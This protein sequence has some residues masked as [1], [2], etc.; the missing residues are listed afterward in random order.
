MNVPVAAGD[1]GFLIFS[2]TFEGPDLYGASSFFETMPSRPTQ[3]GADIGRSA[4]KAQVQL[5]HLNR[6]FRF[7]YGLIHRL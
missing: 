3:H 4:H 2:H 5:K 6:N 7:P 1:F